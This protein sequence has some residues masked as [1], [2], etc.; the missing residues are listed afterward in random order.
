MRS[1]RGAV[2]QSVGRYDEAVELLEESLRLFRP[3]DQGT[4]PAITRL[5]LGEAYFGQGRIDDADAEYYGCLTMLWGQSSPEIPFVV[6]WTLT[7]Q[8]QLAAVRGQFERAAH[9]LGA[10]EAIRPPLLIFPAE[11]AELE[12]AERLTRAALGEDAFAAALSTLENVSV[13]EAIAFG[14]DTGT[15]G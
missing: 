3:D 4:N 10:R 1:R 11:R 9:L 7:A 12:D 2:L 13:E 15:S 8:A 6:A 5:N 14:L